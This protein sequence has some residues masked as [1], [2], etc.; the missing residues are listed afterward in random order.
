MEGGPEG[1]TKGRELKRFGL[2]SLSRKFLKCPM[3][4]MILT[5]PRFEYGITAA[6][7]PGDS[8]PWQTLSMASVG[9]SNSGITTRPNF[10]SETPSIDNLVDIRK[11][12]GKSSLSSTGDP[13]FNPPYAKR[14]HYVPF[15]LKKLFDN[16]PG[17]LALSQREFIINL[18][19]NGVKEI[20][21]DY[22]D[23]YT[24]GLEDYQREEKDRVHGHLLDKMSM[25]HQSKLLEFKLSSLRFLQ[26]K[27]RSNGTGTRLERERRPKIE[28]YKGILGLGEG[29]LAPQHPLPLRLYSQNLHPPTIGAGVISGI[30][31]GGGALLFA[32]ILALVFMMKRRNAIAPLIYEGSPSTAAAQTDPHW[33]YI[34]NQRVQAWNGPPI[35]EMEHT[36]SLD[37]G[38]GGFTTPETKLSI[39]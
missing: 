15:E 7:K 4:A 32:F 10:P 31:I 27:P 38:H 23:L 13:F 16:V 6:F 19:S 25:L 17:Y 29:R 18:L 35:A 21:L 33:S 11:H 20:L 26:R 5:S 34:S 37:I 39:Q 1:D 30:V 2:H 9:N 28:V 12:Y 14:D 36:D 8:S 22:E 24:I 3:L